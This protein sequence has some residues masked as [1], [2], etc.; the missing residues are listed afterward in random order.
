MSIPYTQ[1]RWS[2]QDL[3]PE[4]DGPALQAYLDQLD[5]Y[6]MELEAARSSLSPEIPVAEFLRLLDAYEGQSHIA[7]RLSAYVNLWFFEDTQNS[8]ALT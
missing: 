7:N 3:L 1:S 4:P 6:I 2:L 8:A 5:R